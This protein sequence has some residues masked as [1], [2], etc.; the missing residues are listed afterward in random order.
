M[1][2]GGTWG[3]KE[4][5]PQK[6]GLG[7]QSFP[8]IL[9]NLCGSAGRFCRTFD[10]IESLSKRGSAEPQRFSLRCYARPQ[11][12]CPAFEFAAN[13]LSAQLCPLDSGEEP[14]PAFQ[15]L[16]VLPIYYQNSWQCA[17][18]MCISFL[19]A[20]GNGL[21]GNACNSYLALKGCISFLSEPF[22]MG[23]VQFS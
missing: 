20:S 12:C 9:R 15:A 1:G 4:A 10:T 11:H 22:A 14:S 16:Q 3:G 19:R 21:C 18:Q 2:G 23:P 5:G 17:F 7:S 13:H 8:R 6:T